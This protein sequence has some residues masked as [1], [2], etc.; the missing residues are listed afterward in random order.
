MKSN[1]KRRYALAGLLAFVVATSSFAFAAQ[2]TVSNSAVGDGVGVV[3]GY[4]VTGVTW[5]LDNANPA[6]VEDVG[7][8]VN[9]AANEV[10][11]RIDTDATA[12]VSWTS[13][14]SC[15]AGAGTTWTCP[16]SGVTALSVNGLEVASAS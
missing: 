16:L 7:F 15:N 12:A 1:R 3:S 9:A 13:W 6:N 8:D 14:S 5:D 11:V 10:W 4:N 2:N